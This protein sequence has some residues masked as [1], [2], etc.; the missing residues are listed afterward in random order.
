MGGTRRHRPPARTHRLDRPRLARPRLRGRQL[1]LPAHDD[2][3]AD[4]GGAGAL[5]EHPE[6]LYRPRL[7]RPRR[8]LRAGGLH[9]HHPLRPLRP[10]ALVGHPARHG[11]RACS[12]PS[13]SAIPRS[14][15]AD[16]ISHSPC[17]PIRLALLYVFEWLGYQEVALP[18]KRDDPARY[19]QFS[20]Y[21][22]YIALALGLLVGG[23]PRLARGRA[24]ALRLL[25]PR[26][27]AERA[28]RGG[29][30]HRHARLEDARDHALRRASQPPPAA[31]T[32][33]CCSW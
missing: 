11:R 18:M 16:I 25:A 4:L 13:S 8:L 31:S 32:R 10:D 7:L 30:G 15:C 9:R 26:D 1:L 17:W 29:G 24:L 6:R 5:L 12:R 19:M 3:G 14:A 20:D 22:V 21:R 23:P 33:S 27:Q 28:G 2:P